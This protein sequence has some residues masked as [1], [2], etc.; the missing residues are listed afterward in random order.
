VDIF[1]S[2]E[3]IKLP[4][5]YVDIRPKK[6]DY[7]M[8]E[9]S[10]S[11]LADLFSKDILNYYKKLMQCISVMEYLISYLMTFYQLSCKPDSEGGFENKIWEKIL[12]I[13]NILSLPNCTEDKKKEF[14]EFCNNN[15][16]IEHIS[17]SSEDKEYNYFDIKQK[18]QNVRCLFDNTKKT[19]IS[20]MKI[21]I[22]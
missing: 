16:I 22:Y 1:T 18:M 11:R 8:I 2:I 6:K 15:I 12:E 21:Y 20:Q 7:K 19:L 10:E 13:E 9:I 14:R 4:D 5:Y 3:K 17:E